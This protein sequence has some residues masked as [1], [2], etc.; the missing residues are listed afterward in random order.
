MFDHLEGVLGGLTLDRHAGPIALLKVISNLQHT[1]HSHPDE[2]A[3]ASVD[4]S[5]D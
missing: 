4:I 3:N 1:V 5:A 2:D